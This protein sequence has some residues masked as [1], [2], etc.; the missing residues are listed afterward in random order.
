M[1]GS[2]PTPRNVASNITVN[3]PSPGVY[4]YELDYAKGGDKN[5]TLTLQS[6]GI[7]IPAAALL[8]LTPNAP[9][10]IQVDQVQTLNLAATDSEGLAIP[11][12]PVTVTV[13]GNNPQTRPLTTDGTGQ[14]GFS[15]AGVPLT[16]PDQVQATALND[17][18]PIYS[19]VVTVPWNSG[20]NQAP[21]VSAGGPQTIVLPNQA[22]L[23]GSVSDDG[24]PSNTLTITWSM[25]SGPALVTFDDPNQAATAAT[26]IAPGT[27][28]CS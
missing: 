7:S 22:I 11:S 9:P 24:L 25:Q 8:T 12:L 6:G 16:G 27:Y 21:I 19:N 17:G 18:V 3:F 10:S 28:V 13:T 2:Q 1:G 20:S 4:P 14:I 5:L 26:F 15:Y 23:T